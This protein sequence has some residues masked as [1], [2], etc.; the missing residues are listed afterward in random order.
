M[1]RASSP[2]PTALARAAWRFESWRRSRTTQRIPEELWSLAADLGARFGV[3][4][5]ARAL[6]IQYYD[7]KKRVPDV[8]RDAPSAKP[9]APAFVEILTAPST[10][11]SE[12]VVEFESSAGDKMRVEMKG[13][14]TSDIMALSKLFLGRR[15]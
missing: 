14:K 1:A 3:S 13:A 4:R 8:L 7:L 9:T 11:P 12:C 5:T 15:P 2:L 6:R 10:M